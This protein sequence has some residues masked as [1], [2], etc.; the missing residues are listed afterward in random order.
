MKIRQLTVLPIFILISLFLERDED[1]DT[2]LMTVETGIYLDS[3]QNQVM[4]AMDDENPLFY[5]ANIFTPV[6]NTGECLPVKINLYWNLKGEYIQ[7]DQ[8]DGEILT[9]LDHVPF[10]E[11]DYELLNEILTGPDPRY[12]EL[13]KHS[14]RSEGKNQ[15]QANP[16]PQAV[17][18]LSKY[19]MVDG[20]TGATALEIQDKFVPGA[21]Y[22]TY[23]LWGLANDHR[24]MIQNY[25]STQLIKPEYY[26]ILLIK[27]EYNCVDLVIEH[28][29]IKDG[30][31]EF[32]RDNVLLSFLDTGDVSLQ[33]LTLNQFYWDSYQRDEVALA[34]HNKFYGDSHVSIRKLILMR[35]AYNFIPPSSLNMLSVNL[36]TNEDLLPEIL[37]VFANKLDWND[38]LF[39]NLAGE[40]DQLNPENQKLLLQ[41]FENRKDNLSYPQKKKLK[42][43]KKSY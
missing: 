3:L 40:M 16:G 11:N 5:F 25:T 13:E 43:L 27:K 26:Q 10:T 19:E 1:E 39:N 18:K 24:D 28:L 2:I 29:R 12:E 14:K 7:F 23:T 37:A 33:L 30:G 9:K 15:D 42:E 21:L 22:T 38:A 17:K 32:S 20:I 31:K 41:M 34:L 8:D 36:H 4:L 35:W 6:C